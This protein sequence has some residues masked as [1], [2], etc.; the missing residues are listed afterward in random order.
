M[1]DIER[2]SI[3]KRI[4]AALLDFILVLILSVG[5]GF[6]VS[7]ISNYDEHLNN[8]NEYYEY[9]NAKYDIDL[10][11]T[12][13]KYDNLNEEEKEAYDERYKQANL[14]YQND[15]EAM[16]EFNLVMN[17]SI[18][19]ISIG[20]FFG[21]FITEFII[22]LFFKNGQTVGKKIFSICI[23]KNDGVKVSNVQLFARTVIGKYVIETMIPVLLVF[24][25]AFGFIG[26]AGTIVI[27]GLLLIQIVLLFATKNR[28]L[29]HDAFA[30]T[31]VVDKESQ[32]IFNSVEEKIKYK[33]KL[34]EEEVSKQKAY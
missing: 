23:I 22:P 14:E 17:L 26:L 6:F 27:I 20:L 31:V 18:V 21:I 28:T 7:W 29:I 24:A 32:K 33:E 8:I 2:A 4:S 15:K 13:D 10:L 30:Y 25:I 16:K 1:F 3:L 11:G 34:H 12:S 19:I 5:F 9:Y